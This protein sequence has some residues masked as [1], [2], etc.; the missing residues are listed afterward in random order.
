M[1]DAANTFWSDPARREKRVQEIREQH[2][3][4]EST[5]ICIGIGVNR[6]HAV[7][8]ERPSTEQSRFW[9]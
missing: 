8:H 4:E 3:T 9:Q 5:I 6:H 7:V 2:E 1:V